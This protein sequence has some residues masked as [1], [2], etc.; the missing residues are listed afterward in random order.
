MT[1]QVAE[2]AALLVAAEGGSGIEGVVGVDPDTAGL[3]LRG[4][5]VRQF[6]VVGPDGGGQAVGSTVGDADGIFGVAKTDGAE[7]RAEDLIAGDPHGSRDVGKNGRL[8]HT[9]AR[10]V[11]V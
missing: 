9:A 10:L 2:E 4:D 8:D 3:D 5:A 1:A 7:D 6:D 11:P